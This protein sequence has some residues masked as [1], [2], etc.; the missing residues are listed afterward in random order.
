MTIWG[1]QGTVGDDILDFDL[2]KDKPE[3]QTVRAHFE[4]Y[5]QYSRGMERFGYG[6]PGVEDVR[7]FPRWITQMRF[8]L[9]ALKWEFLISSNRQN[10]ILSSAAVYQDFYE[11]ETIQ[12]NYP[13]YR[14]WDSVL[15]IYLS[16]N[17]RMYAHVK[18]L[19]NRRHAGIDAT[20]TPDDLLYNPQPGR[21]LRYG[22]S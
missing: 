2:R 9:R 7:N 6:L 10:F 4:F 8:S 16:K 21:M 20:G 11:R 17:F 5:F 3:D 22:G 13:A 15:S 12:R 19:F 18:N 1:I 14:T